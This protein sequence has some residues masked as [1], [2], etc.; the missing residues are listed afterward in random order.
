MT[1]VVESLLVSLAVLLIEL[2][3]KALFRQFRPVAGVI[4]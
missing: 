4:A 3:L 1:S 2:V